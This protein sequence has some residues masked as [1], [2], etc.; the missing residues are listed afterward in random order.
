VLT[1]RADDITA[2]RN[3]LAK[4]QGKLATDYEKLAT[5]YKDLQN[6]YDAVTS[7]KLQQTLKYPF[8][9]LR[10]LS[11]H[12]DTLSDVKHAFDFLRKLDQ[13]T[14]NLDCS[15]KKPKKFSSSKD[16]LQ[17]WIFNCLHYL[18]ANGKNY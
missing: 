4:E 10:G 7:A 8:A 13:Y 14:K 6:K 11:A 15:I 2:K 12:A 3:K 5:A 1:K 18:K 16:A 17:T 9:N